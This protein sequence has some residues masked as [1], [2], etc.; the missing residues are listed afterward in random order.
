[1]I[2]VDEGFVW[3]SYKVRSP[4]RK[5][6]YNGEKL[7]VVDIPISL[8]GIKSLGKESDGVEPAFL[9]PLLK[10]GANSVGGG[11]AID[12]ELIFKSRLS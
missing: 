9:I 8:C 6:V 11:V 2:G 10:D 4:S 7:L 12:D 5:S 3:V 1:M